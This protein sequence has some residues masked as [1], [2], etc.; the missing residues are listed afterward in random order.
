MLTFASNADYLMTKIRNSITAM[1]VPYA[2]DSIKALLL[3]TLGFCSFRVGGRENHF[4]CSKCNL[5]WLKSLRDS[6]K[7]CFT[8]VGNCLNTFTV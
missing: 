1:T 2:G 8:Y 7:V 6:H 3:V 4:H 5:C